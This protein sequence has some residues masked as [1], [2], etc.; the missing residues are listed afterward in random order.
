MKKVLFL[1]TSLSISVMLQAQVS[2]TVNVTTAGTLSTVASTYLNTVTNLTITG[3][4]D[5]VDFI[6]MRDSMP[7]LSVIDLSA[8]S[9]TSNRIPLNAFES[10][11]LISI[12]LPSSVTSIGDNAF[13]GCVSLTSVI[14]SSSVT[15][16]GGGAI[17]GCNGLTSLTIPSS[18]TSIAIH[19]F[20][21]CSGLTSLTIPSSVTSI[22][23]GAFFKCVGLTSLTIPSSVTSIGTHAFD[24]CSHL[25]LLSI[26]SSVTSI[27]YNAFNGCSG[28]TSLIIPASVT[29]IVYFAFYGCSSLTSI[30]DYSVMP[31]DL[32]NS[33]SVFYGVDTTTCTLYVPA[34]S[35]TAYQTANQWK[36]FT[37]IQEFTPSEISTITDNTISLYPNPA[38]TSF[39]VNTT[40]ATVQLYTTHGVLVSSTKVTG[41]QPILV[42]Q[43]PKGVYVVKIITDAGVTI[44]SLLVQ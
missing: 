12:T 42:S 11:S 33:S 15:S 22:G 21:G 8:A 35:L 13:N 1:I 24:G 26:P 18:V 6:T 27:G 32:S 28:L 19:A 25:T 4:I 39:T 16:I 41:G 5:S 37:H 44:K 10:N 9:V 36:A 29:S 20:E 30:Y 23:T 40:A 34:G 38:T 43:L 17:E 31:I 2:K 7:N 14:I 3:T